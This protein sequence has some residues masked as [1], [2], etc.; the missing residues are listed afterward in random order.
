[1]MSTWLCDG[2]SLPFFEPARCDATNCKP[3]LVGVVIQVA[4]HHLQGTAGAD[5]WRRHLQRKACSL[6]WS[7]RNLAALELQHDTTACLVCSAAIKKEGG[8]GP[9]HLAHDSLKEGLQVL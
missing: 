1:M 7:S 3:A 2:H 9:A 5:N 4:H 6:A 8:G